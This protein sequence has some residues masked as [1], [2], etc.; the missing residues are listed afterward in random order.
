[1]SRFTKK[2]ILEQAEVDRLRQRQLN[3]YSPE[4]HTLVRLQDQIIN[5]LGREDLSAEEKL[6]L[7]SSTDSRFSNLKR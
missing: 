5:I 1:M 2:L 4:L 3:D 7:I 6:S